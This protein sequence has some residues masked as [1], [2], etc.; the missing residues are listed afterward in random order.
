MKRE[1]VE[2]AILLVDDEEELLFSSQLILRRAGF[3]NVLTQSDSR[4]V[5]ELLAEQPVALVLLDMTMPHVTGSELLKQIKAAYPDLAVIMV[6]AVNCLETAVAC[7]RNGADNYLVK[8]VEKDCLIA[9]VRTSYEL[10]R[11]RCDL[12]T[13]RR[14]LAQ[15]TLGRETA[16]SKIVT[17]SP[18]MRNIFLYLES[19]APSRQPVLITGETGTGKELAARAVHDLSGRG[20]PFVAINLAGLD[21]AMFSDTLFGHQRGA[22]TGAERAREGLIRQASGGTLFLDEIGDLTFSS[23]VKLLRLLQ[24]G[25]YLP[26]G[27]DKPQK[28]DVRVVAATHADLKSLME[29]GGFRPDLYYRLCAHRVELPSL[30][31]RCEDIPLLLA[32]FLEKAAASLGKPC[33]T[34]PPELSRYL[35]AYRFPGNIR[36]LEAMVHDAVAR[37]NGRILP[38]EPF[39]VAIGRDL[40]ASCDSSVFESRCPVCPFCNG[41]P[42]LKDA[43]N[44]LIREA[45]R[46]ADNNQRLAATYLGI[47]R[48]A[49]NKR[50]SRSEP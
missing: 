28:S 38:L 21:D 14:C 36:E 27:A 12:E 39:V 40:V 3:K 48:Q 37:H 4:R 22:F 46:L 1:A 15:G 8:P 31:E 20:G 7:M 24:E 34:V 2:P 47:T 23:Q 33:Q 5:M 13:L 16:F 30:R 41:F 44:Q 35:K 18:R 25:E 17:A 43:E 19:V 10:A 49:L 45:L 29:K 50:L 26:L 9:T 11:T 42:T 32:H 6:T